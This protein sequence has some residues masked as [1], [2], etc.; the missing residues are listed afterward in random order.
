MLGGP[1]GPKLCSEA[2][3]AKLCISWGGKC[4]AVSTAISFFLL[5]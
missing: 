2:D 4:A 5:S 3:F 1:L